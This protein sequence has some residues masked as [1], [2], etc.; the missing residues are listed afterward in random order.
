[1]VI[2]NVLFFGA[3]FC[4]E[5]NF[6]VFFI[7]FSWAEN[8]NIPFQKNSFDWAVL[9]F[10]FS[11]NSI[12]PFNNSF[13]RLPVTS[14]VVDDPNSSL[15]IEV[16]YL[17]SSVFLMQKLWKLLI[18]C[19]NQ[20]SDQCYSTLIYG[21]FNINFPPQLGANR[22]RWNDFCL[23]SIFEWCFFVIIWLKSLKFFMYCNNHCFN[24]LVCYTMGFDKF[25]K[26]NTIDRM[27]FL[28][29]QIS[30]IENWQWIF[31]NMN[32]F[33]AVRYLL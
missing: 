28:F 13:R 3:F 9:L 11:F 22:N 14:T 12:F 25:F 20:L 16:N 27:H 2:E 33:S 23:N 15:W 17:P 24:P 32:F 31:K 1:M 30:K 19:S 10:W 8:T 29:K 18:F 26:W 5:W 7:S 6:I 4:L 21:F